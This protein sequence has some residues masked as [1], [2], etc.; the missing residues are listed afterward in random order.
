M[1]STI[2]LSK[3]HSKKD[4]RLQTS[5]YLLLQEKNSHSIKMLWEKLVS[6]TFILRISQRSVQPKPVISEINLLL[7]ET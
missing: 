4:K 3:W 1:I 7:L 6:S 5:L 2:T